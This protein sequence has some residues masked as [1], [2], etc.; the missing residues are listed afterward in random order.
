MRRLSI[1]ALTTA[2]LLSACGGSSITSGSSS[3]SSGGSSGVTNITLTA[4]PTTIAADGST[5][6]TITAIAK[7]SSNELVTGATLTVTSSA[8]NLTL[9]T[10]VTDS[11]GQVTA[12]LTAG[13]AAAGTAITV[14]ATSGSGKA[15]TVVTVADT[16]QTL[17]LTTS[18]PQIPSNGL[19]TATITAL[20]LDASNNFVQGATVAFTSDSG[21]L[22]VT[23]GTT[24]ANGAA[25]ATLSVAGNPQNRTITVTATL[26]SNSATKPQTVPVKVTGTTLTVTG[27]PNLVLGGVGTYTVA[28]LDS[29]GT[30]IPN[31]TINLASAKGNT[32]SASSVTTGSNGQVT[33]TVTAAVSGGDTIT[34]TAFPNSVTPLAPQIATQALTVSSQNFKFTTPAA[35]T[36][37]TNVDLSTPQTLT[38]NWQNQN[39]PVVGALVSFATTRGTLSASSA[40]TDANG[41]ASV[42]ISSAISGE[43]TVTASGTSGATSVSTT[44][45][46]DFIATVPA[47]ISVQASPATIATQGQSTI[48]ATVR[49][50][51]NNLVQGAAV[52]FNTVG[53]IT[54]GTLSVA[55]SQTNAQGQAQTV[56]TASSTASAS[57]GVVVAA[58]V[59]NTT[60]TNTASLTVGGQ[61]VFLSLGTGNTISVPVTNPVNTQF[62]VP[63]TVIA[64]DAAGNP[65][66]GANITLTIKALYYIKGH[67]VWDATLG[68]QVPTYVDQIGQQVCPNEDSTSPVTAAQFNG[69]LDPGEDG[70]W[71]GNTALHPYAESLPSPN[72]AGYACNPY[73]NGN[74]QL[75]PGGTAVASPSSVTTDSTGSAGFN[76]IYP[77]DEA[78]WV[79]VELIA[80]TSVQ[81]TASTA[82]VTF[83]LPVL[84]SDLTS[85][86][87]VPPG[88]ISPYGQGSTCTDPN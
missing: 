45:N 49:D 40:T 54:G 26:T 19:Q 4:S 73:G 59:A 51:N 68:A 78:N 87:V 41:N 11:N 80:T 71:A 74:N 47:S 70:C 29:G 85:E 52:N 34:A 50:A 7:N 48:T 5:S 22:T 53:D 6:S 24:G 88:D 76:V 81:G 69:V 42:S 9:T 77:Q 72:P 12:T 30:G 55:T 79:T 60:I 75:D 62:A 84:A 20:V 33:F 28:L 39:A 37:L 82:S 86:S 46:L 66:T 15:T 2:W 67:Y 83:T 18:Q 65:V 63:Y 64:L 57:N 43:A 36:A 35:T 16:K 25:T 3:S 13:A 58:T 21:G 14:T 10:D 32:L 23:Q 17:E 38:A 8:G 31:S 1:I 27:P 61:S 56:Y 44:A